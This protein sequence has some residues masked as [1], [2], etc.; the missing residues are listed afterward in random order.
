MTMISYLFRTEAWEMLK[1]ESSG[2][3]SQ[4]EDKLIH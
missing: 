3:D 4:L 2:I 1:E